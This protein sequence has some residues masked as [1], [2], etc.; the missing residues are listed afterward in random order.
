MRQTFP[1]EIAAVLRAG[2]FQEAGQT[3]ILAAHRE[4]PDPGLVLT[5]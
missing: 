3:I 2:G 1:N 4:I 5:A